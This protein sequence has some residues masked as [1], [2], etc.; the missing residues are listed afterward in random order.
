[1]LL[2]ADKKYFYIATNEVHP[3][4]R[5]FYRLTIATQKQERITT[6]TGSNMVS[7]SPDE[8]Y[9]AILY[10]YTNKPWEL[11]LQE[12]KPG[13]K[14]QQITNKAQSETFASY[15]WRDAE[16]I[17]FT[18]S[19]PHHMPIN[20]PWYLC[21]APAIY[22]MHTNGGAVISEN[23]CLTTCWPITVIMCWI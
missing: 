21:M 9:L 14:L 18:A 10:S 13:G 4:E 5:Q 8:K 19:P 1:V 15:P 16:V 3:G 6:L 7:V 2:S 11:Y 22:K 12:N 17:S 20:P 23:I